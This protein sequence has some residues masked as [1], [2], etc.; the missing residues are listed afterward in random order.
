[1]LQERLQRRAGE[2]LRE[3]HS[4]LPSEELT[5]EIQQEIIDAVQAYRAKRVA[6]RRP[7]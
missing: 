5:E 4:R 3:I 2:S 6:A 7:Q 1:M